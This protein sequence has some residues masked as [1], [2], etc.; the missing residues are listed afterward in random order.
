MRKTMFLGVLLISFVFVMPVSAQKKPLQ[1]RD[2]FE[3]CF[4]LPVYVEQLKTELTYP[5]AW[6]NSPVKKFD[7]WKAEARKK[8]FECMMA[9]P[10]PAANFAPEIVATEKRDGYTAQKIA[11]NINAYSRVTAIFLFPMEK[12]HFLPSMPCTTTAHIF[13]SA[14]R[15]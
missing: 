2:K 15:K 6:G 3:Y 7:K 14:K 1:K 5:M 10:R 12:G 13:L 9:P 8:V 11:F 4:E